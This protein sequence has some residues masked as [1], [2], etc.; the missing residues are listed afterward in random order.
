MDKSLEKISSREKYIQNQF[1][2]PTESYKAIQGSMSEMKQGFQGAQTKVAE[3]SLE[4]S[5]VSEELE[6]V[7]VCFF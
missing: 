5:R 1:E 6:R 4:L 2:A 7:K 3:L